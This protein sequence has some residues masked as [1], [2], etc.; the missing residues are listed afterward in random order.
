[1]ISI[2]L[3]EIASRL[4]PLYDLSMYVIKTIEISIC[5]LVSTTL[6]LLDTNAQSVIMIC[7]YMPKVFVSRFFNSMIEG[8][9]CGEY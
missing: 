6:L 1:M 3:L 8:L 5:N 9:C 7:Y 4:D 2:I